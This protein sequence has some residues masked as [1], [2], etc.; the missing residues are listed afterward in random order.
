[1][2]RSKN[3][4]LLLSKVKDGVQNPFSSVDNAI[5]AENKKEVKTETNIPYEHRCKI[6]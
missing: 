2:S 6:P 3:S 1:M 5:E 4:Q